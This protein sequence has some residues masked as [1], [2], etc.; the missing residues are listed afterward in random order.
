MPIFL[1]YYTFPFLECIWDTTLLWKAGDHLLK[2][3]AAISK[4]ILHSFGAKQ[5][6]SCHFCKPRLSQVPS[7]L[8]QRRSYLLEES[9]GHTQMWSGITPGSILEISPGRPRGLY[10]CQDQTSLSCVQG[11]CLTLFCTSYLASQFRNFICLCFAYFMCFIIFFKSGNWKDCNRSG[12]IILFIMTISACK[13][14][15]F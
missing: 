7:L 1:L 2:Y 15:I 4:Q 13:Q 9:G 3:L 11:K 5:G 14:C 8:V 10:L 12:L 6:S